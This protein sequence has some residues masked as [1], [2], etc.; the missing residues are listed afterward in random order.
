MLVEQMI[1]FELREARPPNR[2]CTP[3]S[4]YFHNKTKISKANNTQVIIYC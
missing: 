2:T 1:E 3:E 4:G